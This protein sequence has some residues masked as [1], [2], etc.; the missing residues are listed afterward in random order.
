MW[1]YAKLQIL[2]KSLKNRL[3]WTFAIVSVSP[4]A[5]LNRVVAAGVPGVAYSEALAGEPESFEEAVL[6][7]GFGGVFGTPKD[8]VYIIQE[9]DSLWKIS[10]KFNVTI[11]N[12]KSG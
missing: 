6:L 9:G 11:D 1:I 8:R 7:E 3:N 10:K 5:L 12:L 4:H 2:A